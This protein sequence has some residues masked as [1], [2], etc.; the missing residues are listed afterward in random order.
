[1][2]D[3]QNYDSYINIPSSQTYRA[4]KFGSFHEI[5]KILRCA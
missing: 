2:D 3:V 4:N 1:M 5:N